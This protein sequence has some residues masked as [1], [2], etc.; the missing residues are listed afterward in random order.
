MVVTE[1]E[2][3]TKN[4]RKGGQTNDGNFRHREVY[5]AAWEGATNEHFDRIKNVIDRMARFRLPSRRRQ[6]LGKRL[7][8]AERFWARAVYANP[9]QGQQERRTG[10]K[11]VIS[12]ELTLS[13]S[14][15]GGPDR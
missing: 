13:V 12:G 14:V 10:R 4:T 3:S 1:S 6:T 5:G 11:R 8:Q 7:R 15:G 9:K 2:G